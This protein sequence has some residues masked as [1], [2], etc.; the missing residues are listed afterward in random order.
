MLEVPFVSVIIPVFNDQERLRLCL[1]ALEQQSYP[2]DRFEVIVVDNNSAPPV[3]EV[4]TD[5]PLVR[6]LEERRPGSYAARKRGIAES[7]G[8]VLAFTDSDCIPDPHWIE[9]GVRTLSQHARGAL[10]GGK[11]EVF[12]ALRERPRA[13][14][15]YE[16]ALAF[17]QRQN[18]E[19]HHFAVTANVFTT[20]TVMERVG[21]FDPALQSGG[22]REWGGRAFRAGVPL[23]YAAGAVV[24][25]P[26]RSS[27]GEIARKM[28]RIAHG[29]HDLA[30]RRPLVARLADWPR[31]LAPPIASLA[32]IARSDGLSGPSE[33][34]RAGAV[35]VAVK[36]IWAWARI[37]LTLGVD[38]KGA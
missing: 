10:V 21:A 8:E 19:E 3:R 6:V 37:R 31:I 27:L 24:L 28:V 20:R 38:M 15:L 4:L 34:L 17:R 11:V 30:R 26:A 7:R 33:R 5:R 9:E 32:Q 23:V 14:E 2:R 13:V 16:M 29:H 1:D 35:A 25:H 12:A 36:Y 22:D 18:I